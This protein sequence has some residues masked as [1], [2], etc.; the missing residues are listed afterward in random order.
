MNTATESEKNAS[1]PEVPQAKT[2]RTPAK[3]TKPAKNAA[4]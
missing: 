2:K 4:G 3:Q 1:A